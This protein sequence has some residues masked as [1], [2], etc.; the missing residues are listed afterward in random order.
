MTEQEIIEQIGDDIWNYARN[1]M[2]PNAN[3]V[4]KQILSLTE[5]YWKERCPSYAQV[6]KLM[7]YA[8]KH[9]PTDHHDWQDILDLC[10]SIDPKHSQAIIALLNNPNSEGE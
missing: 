6:M 10:T 1:N 7:V 9:C 4:A 2:T 5:Q 3:Q 8:V